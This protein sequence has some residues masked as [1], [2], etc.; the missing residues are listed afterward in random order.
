MV[1]APK[2]ALGSHTGDDIAEQLTDVL[3]EYNICNHVTYFAANN[4]TNDDKAL[5]L[6]T[7]NL[8]IDPVKQRLRCVA[9]SLKLV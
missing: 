8:E 9:H 3:S 1:I 2:D 5:R 4:V 6:L 7:R